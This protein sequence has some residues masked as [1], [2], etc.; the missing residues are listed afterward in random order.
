MFDEEPKLYDLDGQTIDSF[1]SM[2]HVHPR[3][4]VLSSKGYP[5]DVIDSDQP[6]NIE[7]HR[8]LNLKKTS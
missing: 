5:P 8:A 1:H 2:W 7:D 4:V 3:V 6:D